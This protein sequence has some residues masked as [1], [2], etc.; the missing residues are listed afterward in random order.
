MATLCLLV[1]HGFLFSSVYSSYIY[2]EYM[3]W[4][5]GS[6]TQLRRHIRH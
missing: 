5:S 6:H 4:C 3:A 1:P 2:D